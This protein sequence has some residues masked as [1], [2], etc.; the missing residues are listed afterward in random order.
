VVALISFA[1]YTMRGDEGRLGRD[2]GVFVYGGEH[3]ARGIPPY[4]GIFNS[5]GPLADAVPGLAIWLGHFVGADPVLAARL[6]FLVLSAVSCALVSVLARDT[7]GSRAAGFVAPAVFLT[8]LEYLELAASGPREKTTMVVFMLAAMILLGR[9]RWLAAGLFT[10]LAT[11]TW[12]PVLAVL[13]VAFAAA[14]V[15]AGAGRRR[16]LTS[17]LAGGLIPSTLTV[18]YFLA[19]GALHTAIDGFIVVNLTTHQPGVLSEPGDTWQKLWAGYSYSLLVAIA[20]LVGVLALAARAS[21]RVGGRDPSAERL[22]VV[23]AGTL[24]GTVWTLNVING[25]PDLFVLLPFAALGVT[26]VLL[27]ALS[28]VPRRLAA[29]VVVLVTLVGVTSAGAEAVATRSDLLARERADVHAV[30]DTE[31]PGATVVSVDAPE[32]LALAGR[33]NPTSL[34]L[35][36]PPMETYL[37]RHLVGGLT[38]Y[39]AVLR[40]LHP[41]FVAV[42]D[43]YDGWWLV[44]MLQQDYRPVGRAGPWTWYISRSAGRQAWARAH[45][46]NA[47]VMQSPAPELSTGA[48]T[49][50]VLPHDRAQVPRHVGRSRGRPARDRHDAAR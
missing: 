47:R 39:G 15:V 1:V 36:D 50:R 28:H 14:V 16:A 29:G 5:V 48:R 27:L 9:R 24:A 10:A 46:A 35:F 45:L 41:T 8:F 22:V 2:L 37:D 11:L 38:G 26:G 44:S 20:G 21:R 19:Q 31:P 3:V 13:L 18:A 49:G 43:E 34:Q 6:L 30:L 25:A 42:G 32:V 17:F 23:G 33:D 7:F 12:Q 4:V 40:R